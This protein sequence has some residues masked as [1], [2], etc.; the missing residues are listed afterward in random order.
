MIRVL[1]RIKSMPWA[2]DQ[3]ALA[4][5]LEIAERENESPQAVA[6]KLG[7]PLENTYDVEIRDGVAILSVSGPLFRYANL[8]TAISGATS[9][10][11]LA[12]DFA[13]A[14]AN[15]RVESIV[16]NI[17]SPGGEANGVSEFA[18]QI[19]AARGQKPI[20]AYVGGQASSA[21]YWIASAADEIVADETAILGSIGAVMSVQDTR[22]ADAKAGKKRYDIVSSQSPDKRL[23]PATDDGRAK[24]QVLL[25][26][27]AD[28]FIDKVARNRG[29]SRETVLSDFGK[30]GVFVGQAAVGAGL[31]DRLGS[32]EAVVAELQQGERRPA[33]T[34]RI[35]AAGGINQEDIM[36]EKTVKP[37]TS[38]Q[39]EAITAASIAANHPDV[40]EALRA[41]GRT[42]G[43]E[44]GRA[45]GR[46]EGA[47]AERERVRGI[48]AHAEAVDRPALAQA[49]AFTTDMPVEAAAA[50]LAK[51]AKE[52]KP[53]QFA[54]FDAAMR[55]AGNPAVGPDAD[56][57]DKTDA[58]DAL[59]NTA[60]AMG[61]A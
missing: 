25:D 9:Y 53:S 12:R 39:P 31:A 18:D 7:R 27:L 22:E 43:E 37:A 4:Q 21:A 17:D 5:I 54:G 57:K 19:H 58:G 11:V 14:L 47:T 51:A 28:V 33:G 48:L 50:V 32:F 16:L 61:L 24:L 38:T 45:A 44:S 6:A 23:D 8:F 56:P 46:T 15:P 49:L 40:A 30:G 29:E 3:A 59:I 42:G 13:A 55:A 26:S 41:E 60:K 20:V 2:I 35:A 36:S 1:S 52:G 34:N 10:D